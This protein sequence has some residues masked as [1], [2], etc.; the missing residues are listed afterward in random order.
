MQH[1][2]RS[3]GLGLAGAALVGALAGSP[4]LSTAVHHHIAVRANGYD[5]SPGAVLPDNGYDTSPGAVPSP[6]GQTT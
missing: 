1:V 6:G 5:T 4:A 3:V 2:S